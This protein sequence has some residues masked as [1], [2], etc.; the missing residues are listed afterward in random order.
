MHVCCI[1]DGSPLSLS[2]IH[3][4]PDSTGRSLIVS[5]RLGSTAAAPPANKLLYLR[6]LANSRY[7][8]IHTQDSP[9]LIID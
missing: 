4:L 9:E 5:S 2:F 1:S 8:N 3:T 6:A 7:N